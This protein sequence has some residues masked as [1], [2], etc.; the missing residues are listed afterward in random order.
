VAAAL[1]GASSV[2]IGTHV[3][4]DGDT[5]GSALALL[6]ALERAGKR[7]EVVCHDTVPHNLRFLPRWEDVHQAP[8]VGPFDVGVL[9]DLEGLSRLASLAPAFKALPSLV[10][11]DHHIPSMEL[12]SVRFVDKHAASTAELILRVLRVMGTPIDADIATCALTGLVTDTGG[13]RF[14]NTRPK[15]LVLAAKLVRAGANLSEIITEA[16]EKRAFRAQRVLGLALST[17]ERSR[18]GHVVWASLRHTDFIDSG[19]TDPD[20]DG[21]VNYVRAVDGADIAILFRETRPNRVRVSLRSHGTVNVAEIAKALGGGGHANAAGCSFE[22]GLDDARRCTLAE[23][24]RW[25][26]FSL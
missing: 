16:Y 18:D 25:T 26:G 4:P 13:F 1:Q 2:L 12:G 23:V 17:L 8:G 15:H 3:N 22:T 19:A 14:P 9:V 21:I 5:L 6:L 24:V 7:A 20:T 10:T 11:I